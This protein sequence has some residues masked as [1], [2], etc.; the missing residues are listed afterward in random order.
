MGKKAALEKALALASYWALFGDANLINTEL[1]RY[2]RV[3]RQDLQRV[4]QTY[5]TDDRV[6]LTYFPARVRSQ[7]D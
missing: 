6:V 5:F 3:T 4:A 1:Q 7:S 2:L